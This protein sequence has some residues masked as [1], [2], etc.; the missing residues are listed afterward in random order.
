MDGSDFAVKKIVTMDEEQELAVEREVAAHRAFDHPN[1]MPLLGFGERRSRSTRD[2]YFV[3]PL[4]DGSLRA[5]IDGST[6][7]DGGMSRSRMLSVLR[8][9][10]EGLAAVHARD[11]PFAHRDIK[12]ENVL[13]LRGR[14]VLMDFG[15][16]GAAHRGAETRRLAM[17]IQEEAAEQCTMPYRAPEL[18]DVQTGAA[19]DEKV[20]VWSVG[21]LLYAMCY[22]Y[23]PAECDFP[24]GAAAP[25]VVE[26]SY[27]KVLAKVAYPKRE[28]VSEGIRGILEACLQQDP[29]KRP[30]VPEVIDMV[31]AARATC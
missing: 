10:L 24:H 1:L 3:F 16:M 4:C 9:V 31:D 13:F 2:F 18:W 8:D 12:P 30:S 15:S 7:R 23:S 11:P 26:T 27:L 5:E 14:A 28:E 22:G 17:A 29:R 21:C 6:L 19:V 25:R 20:D